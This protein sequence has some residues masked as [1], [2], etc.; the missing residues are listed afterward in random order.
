MY[1]HKAPKYNKTE[2]EIRIAHPQNKQN[3][4]F[5]SAGEYK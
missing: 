2:N 3:D 1:Q 5:F 4:Y